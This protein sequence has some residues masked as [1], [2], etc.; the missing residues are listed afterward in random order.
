M[1]KTILAV[2]LII[3]M[4]TWVVYDFVDKPN[5]E[6]SSDTQDN[7]VGDELD[8]TE[9]SATL[10]ESDKIGLAQ[11]NKAPDFELSTLD[12][13]TVRLSDFKGQKVMLNFW[14]TWCPPCRAEM[15]DMQKLHENENVVVLAVNLTET[16]S[17]MENISGFVEELALTFPILLDEKIEVAGLYKIQPI[18]TSYLIDT[19]GHIYNVAFGALH[20]KTM[21]EEFEK[22]K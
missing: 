18:P 3:G 10:Q 17:S 16:E 22:M 11:G 4:L 6:A 12:G 2:L 21:V 8:D 7:K 14:A 19:T 13:K 5:M 9:E 15:P 1:K 20:Y